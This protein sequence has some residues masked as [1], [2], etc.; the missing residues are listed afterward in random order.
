MFVNELFNS[1]KFSLLEIKNTEIRSTKTIITGM[2]VI[3]VKFCC[4]KKMYTAKNNIDLIKTL[5]LK[6]PIIA[7]EC[8]TKFIKLILDGP[9][10]L[11]PLID[12]TEPLTFV[13]LTREPEKLLQVAF[14]AIIF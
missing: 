11:V 1:S 6:T 10:Y 2:N 4:I 14:S 9:K 13:T 5:S 12:F 3:T 8:F 7:N